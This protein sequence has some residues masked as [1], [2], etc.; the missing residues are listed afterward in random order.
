MQ[1][2]NFN[3]DLPS[4]DAP[5]NLCVRYGDLFF[6][7]GLPPFDEAFSAKV[8]EA[9]ANKLPLPPFPDMP[10]ADQVH[11]VMGNMKKLVEEAGSNMDCL[12]KVIVWLKDQRDAGEFD[13]IYRTYFSG[14]D[15]LPARTRMQAG[16]TPMD[17]GLEVEAIGYVPGAV[18]VAKSAAKRAAKKPAKKKAASKP[19]KNAAKKTVKKKR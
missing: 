2:Q 6:V 17:C 13:R 7:S 16:R 3:A 19:V 4:A 8:R 10:F 9:R 5:F 15:A 14:Q 18:R 12:L 1:K 11:L